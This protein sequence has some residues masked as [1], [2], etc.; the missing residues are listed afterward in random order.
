MKTEKFIDKILVIIVMVAL[1]GLQLI[2]AWA[3]AVVITREFVVARMR[4]LASANGILTPGSYGGK[5]TTVFQ[6]MALGFLIFKI[7]GGMILIWAAILLT[8]WTGITTLVLLYRQ[9]SK[10]QR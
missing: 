3:V 6:I 5:L 10:K 2:P 7:P 8:V 9:L 4:Q 1:F